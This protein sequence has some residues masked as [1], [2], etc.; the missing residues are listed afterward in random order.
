MF[1][2]LFFLLVPASAAVVVACLVPVQSAVDE[3]IK[4]KAKNKAVVERRSRS[5]LIPTEQSIARFEARLLKRPDDHRSGIVLAKLYARLA[6]ETDDHAAFHEAESRLRSVLQSLPKSVPARTQ[7]ASVLLAQHSFR[8]SLVEADRALKINPKAASALAMKGDAEIELGRYEAA[9]RTYSKL[10]QLE[11]NAAVFVRQAQLSQ[12]TG[13]LHKAFNLLYRA[14]ADAVESDLSADAMAWYELRLATFHH[15]TGRPENARLHYDRALELVENYGPAMVGK[16][17]LLAATD[18]LDDAEQLLRVA[19]ELHGE[20][21]MMAE[22][23][24]VLAL[25]GL[26]SEAKRWL[27]KAEAGMA[28]EAKTAAEPHYRE[29][30]LFLADHQRAPELA[31]EIAEKDFLIRQSIHACDTLAWAQFRAGELADARSNIE[32]ALSTGAKDALIHFHAGMI[33]DA[34]GEATTARVHFDNALRLNPYFSAT[35]AMI[36]EEK[37][38][39]IEK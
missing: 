33:F 10:S 24:D 25:M 13:D 22:L 6:K 27:D 11:E 16:A 26:N 31:V 21:P 18:F 37:R 12:L 28:E 29:Y 38:S 14:Y 9:S 4:P 36:A 15:Q 17:R 34:L 30:A 5:G 32:R 7:L 1:K 23:G 20:P 2:S 3:V 8:E 35:F 39:I 19:V